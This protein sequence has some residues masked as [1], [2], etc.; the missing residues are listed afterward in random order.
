MGQSVVE[1]CQLLHVCVSLQVYGDFAHTSTTT[2]G[3]MAML[4]RI[5]CLWTDV[6][7]FENYRGYAEDREQI[8]EG[9]CR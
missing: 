9:D 7:E 5:T 8:N 6:T 2:T 4:Y 3:A 1:M